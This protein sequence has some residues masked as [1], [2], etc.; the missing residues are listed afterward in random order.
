MKKWK[1]LKSDRIFRSKYVNILKQRCL[2]PNGKI[3]EPYYLIEK[4][5]VALIFA[6][7]GEGKVILVR[8]YKHGAGEELLQLPIGFI[9][10]HEPPKK[11]AIRELAEE[12]GYTAKSVALIGKFISSPS[13][14][15][16]R[17]HLFFAKHAEKRKKQKLDY[18]EDIEVIL[19]SPK[20]LMIALK[21]GEI[22]VMPHIAAIMMIREKYSKLRW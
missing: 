9:E 14:M 19:L 7:T 17:I 13:D 18:T 2:M 15:T 3:A 5:D 10:P 22:N 16:N 8:E 11:A 1:V 21:K 20:Q 4:K 6:L 12:T